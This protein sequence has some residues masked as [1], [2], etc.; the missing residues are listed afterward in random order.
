MLT[1]KIEAIKAKDGLRITKINSKIKQVAENE[2][3]PENKRAIGFRTEPAEEDEDTFE[4]DD[5]DED[6]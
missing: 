1:T 6:D 5:V 2:G 4:E 3:Y